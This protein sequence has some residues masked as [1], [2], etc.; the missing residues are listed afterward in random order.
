[1][2]VLITTYHIHPVIPF[3][4]ALKAA[5]HEVAIAASSHDCETIEKLGMRSFPAGINMGDLMP[6]LIPEM[7]Q[8]PE[9]QRDVW[10][11]E[12][13]WLGA[14]PDRIIPDLIRICRDW[15]PAVIV[16]DTSE[17]GGCIA[18][19]Y[20][21]LPHATIEI[22]AFNG[23]HADNRLLEAVRRHMSRLRAAY[24]LPADPD[25]ETLYRYLHLSFVPPSYQ[26]PMLPMP[27]TTHAFRTVNFDRSGD[28]ALP[29]WIADLPEQPTI[30]ATLGL[31]IFNRT[32]GIFETI[33]AGL[34]DEA[35]NLIVTVGRGN[36]PARFGPQPPNVHI[37]SYVPQTLLLPHCDLVIAHGGWNTVLAA[38]SHD[39]P[40][41]VIPLGA[42]QP[43][44][45]QRVAMLQ[46]GQVIEPARL[47]PAGVRKAA[48]E[49]LRDPVYRQNARRM[50]EEMESL[51]GME[52][53]VALLER[54]A[55][56]RRPQLASPAA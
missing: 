48:F 12:H 31:A 43:L 44:N 27:P 10:M 33:I 11:V 13:V 14:L 41:V 36:D 17:L 18:A 5:G 19:E 49:V 15:Q 7:L 30:L 22:G 56:E 46:V 35:V 47:T 3:A 39:L 2:R 34:R 6:E 9:D 37:E 55:R 23:M 4:Q 21:G 25:L 42:D 29:D 8:Q 16:R 51:P 1:M 50:R 32:P 20:L 45:A 53:A 40:L 54:L 52:Q 28:E 26:D 24:D 38:L